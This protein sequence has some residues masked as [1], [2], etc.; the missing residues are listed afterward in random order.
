MRFPNS[1]FTHFL[2]I[3]NFISLLC[4]KVRVPFKVP[5]ATRDITLK[6]QKKKLFIGVKGQSPIIDGDLHEEVQHEDITWQMEGSTLV[7]TLD[8]GRDL[9]WS[10]L[11]TTD[12]EIKIN[13]YYKRK[14]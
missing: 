1:I 5:V 4:I 3:V 9:W 7:L 8:K 12:P 14:K 2:F 13:P 11:V 10:K 6:V